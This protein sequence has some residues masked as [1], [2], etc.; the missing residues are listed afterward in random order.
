[1]TEAKFTARS[2]SPLLIRQ[3]VIAGLIGAIIVDTYL[4]IELHTSIVA[5]EVRNAMTAFDVG[6][7]I[8]GVIVHLVIALVWA[9]IYAYVFNAIGQ[10]RNW[11]LGTI[12]LGV[13][14]DAVMNLIIMLKIGAP[15]GAGFLGG[16]I[17]NV[18]FYALPVALYLSLTAPRARVRRLAEG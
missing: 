5:L 6:L 2:Q 15:W 8:L 3:A 10:L 9:L 1:M 7:P 11:I 4:S 17:T 12:V 13:V 18:V 16:L 14:L